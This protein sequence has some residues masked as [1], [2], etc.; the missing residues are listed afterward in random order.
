MPPAAAM[1]RDSETRPSQLSG[2][3]A[4]A[5]TMWLWRL[6][7]WIVRLFTRK[8]EVQRLAESKDSLEKRTVQIGNNM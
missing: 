4:I 8:C 6:W 3:I 7:K 5:V 1:P 2:G